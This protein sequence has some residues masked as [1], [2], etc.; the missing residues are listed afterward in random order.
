MLESKL[1]LGCT[2]QTAQ[3]HMPS[4]PY[5][6]IGQ[7]VFSSKRSRTSLNEEEHGLFEQRLQRLQV[8]CTHRAVQRAMVNGQC[9]AQPVAQRDL[10]LI[11]GRLACDAANRQNCRFRRVDDRLKLFDPEHAEVADRKRPA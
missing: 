9:Q 7:T 3:R 1:A 11:F 10:T 6:A 5:V 4:S 2:L 8:A